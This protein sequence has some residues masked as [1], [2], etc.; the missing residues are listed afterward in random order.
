M[1]Q[2]CAPMFYGY[3][4]ETD[5]LYEYG[6]ANNCRPRKEPNNK[7]LP[8]SEV[9]FKSSTILNAKLHIL[10]LAD[11]GD[12]AQFLAFPID[13]E[14]CDCLVFGVNNPDTGSHSPIL[15]KERYAKIREIIGA[16]EEP[17]WWKLKL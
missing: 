17:A 8:D 4:L 14:M 7:L 5:W 3:V 9:D 1:P 11:L 6:M 16:K 2:K 15:P 10:S 12:Y 13:G